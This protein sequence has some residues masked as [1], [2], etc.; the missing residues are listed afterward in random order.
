MVCCKDRISHHA[1]YCLDLLML[2]DVLVH[3]SPRCKLRCKR[4]LRRLGIADCLDSVDCHHLRSSKQE[5]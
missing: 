3:V 4:C 1:F 5:T 2:V